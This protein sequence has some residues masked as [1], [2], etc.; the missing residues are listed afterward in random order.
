MRNRTITAVPGVS[1]GHYTDH[2]AATGVTVLTFP[3]PNV[4]VVDVRGGAPGTRE[5]AT[6]GD[7]I[8]PVTINALTFAGG[9]AFGLAAATGV[10]AEIEAEGR[11]APTPAGPVPIV[12][13]AI[14]TILLT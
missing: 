7:A 12:P 2:A 1:V 8:K 9:S 5:T 11:G 14:E 13:S 10:V 4:A 6:L 3:E